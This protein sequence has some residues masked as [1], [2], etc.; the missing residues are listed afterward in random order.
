M[1]DRPAR[2][3]HLT[4]SSCSVGRCV[5]D[6]YVIRYLSVEFHGSAFKHGIG[7][8]AI[9][10]AVEHGQV[11]IDLDPDAD[12]P[13]LLAIGPDRVGNLLE[14]ICLELADG[15]VMVI[16][17]MPLRRVFYDLLLQGGSND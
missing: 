17:A 1:A 12:P 14:I 16:H 2:L 11:F 13:R 10:H 7:Q 3:G 8:E 9:V 15:R 5:A 4:P 6:F